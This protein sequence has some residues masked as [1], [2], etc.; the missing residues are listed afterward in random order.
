MQQ[1][2][3]GTRSGWGRE[4]HVGAGGPGFR[5]AEPGNA[6]ERRSVLLAGATQPLIQIVRVEFIHRSVGCRRRCLWWLERLGAHHGRGGMRG[7]SRRAAAGAY[8][9]AASL[10]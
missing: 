4:P 1:E 7:P 9:D 3:T 2:V 8:L 10:L 6:L 5:D